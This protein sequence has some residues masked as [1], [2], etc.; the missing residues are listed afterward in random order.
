MYQI[1]NKQIISTQQNI[2]E[3]LN[4]YNTTMH[5]LCQQSE[6]KLKQADKF[7]KQRIATLNDTKAN[8]AYIFKKI[9]YL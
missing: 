2:K 8:L 7:L 6:I 5:T 3:R 4:E 9:R 1:N